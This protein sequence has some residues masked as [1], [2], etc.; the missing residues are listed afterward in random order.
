MDFTYQT[1]GTEQVGILDESMCGI[2]FLRVGGKVH[3][4]GCSRG[5]SKSK[6]S[7]SLARFQ[8]FANFVYG[9]HLIEILV[10]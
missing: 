6:E 10:P 5:A 1:G 4:N 2:E 3:K 7:E 8:K 9:N